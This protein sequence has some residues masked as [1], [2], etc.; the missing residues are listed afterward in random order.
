MTPRLSS[1]LPL[2]E[3]LAEAYV[4]GTLPPD[5]FFEFLT[6]LGFYRHAVR[7]PPWRISAWYEGNEITIY[8]DP[9]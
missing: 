6:N 1:I 8:G 5:D 2:A 7:F 3:R 9:K 4:A